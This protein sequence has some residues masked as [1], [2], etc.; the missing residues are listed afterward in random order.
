MPRREDALLVVIQEVMDEVERLVPGARLRKRDRSTSRTQDHTGKRFINEEKRISIG[1]I[2]K[3]GGNDINGE[4][5]TD[6]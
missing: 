5:S 3:I 2:G 4:P 6:C 1:C